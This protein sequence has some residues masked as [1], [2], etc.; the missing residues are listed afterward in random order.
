[1]DRNRKE[2]SRWEKGESLPEE[3]A[4]SSLLPVSDILP[5]FLLLTA[6]DPTRPPTVTMTWTQGLGQSCPIDVHTTP[7]GTLDS[8]HT[9]T[10]LSLDAAAAQSLAQTEERSCRSRAEE[11]RQTQLAIPFPSFPSSS[12]PIQHSQAAFSVH[13][14]AVTTHIPRTSIL[15]PSRMSTLPPCS[16]IHPFQWEKHDFPNVEV[17]SKIRLIEQV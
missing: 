6:T 10:H 15:V 12:Q 7:S 1:M 3:G 9:L 16:Q 4:C 2:K 14:H 17:G 8:G 13:P 11:R 5:S